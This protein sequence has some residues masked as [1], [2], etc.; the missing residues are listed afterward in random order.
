MIFFRKNK[1]Q[2]GFGTERKVWGF[3]RQKFGAN[4][5]LNLKFGVMFREELGLDLFF[6]FFRELGPCL[7]DGK[8]HVA[9]LLFNHIWLF[10]SLFNP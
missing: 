9:F 8:G 3:L 1:I 5:G 4:L 2:G 10:H 7:S 6:E